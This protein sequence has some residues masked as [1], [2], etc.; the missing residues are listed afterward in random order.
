MTFLVGS[1]LWLLAVGLILYIIY[2]AIKPLELIKK[3]DRFYERH[4]HICTAVV[5]AIGVVAL[6]VAHRADTQND[7]AIRLRLFTSNFRGTT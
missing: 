4:P 7:A 3:S 6:Y 5:V 2:C 1:I